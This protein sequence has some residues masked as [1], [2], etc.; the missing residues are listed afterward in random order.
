MGQH[1]LSLPCE[2]EE[3]A[4]SLPFRAAN[5]RGTK[6]EFLEN[7]PNDPG[8]SPCIKIIRVA[9]RLGGQFCLRSGVAVECTNP[10][11]WL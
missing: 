8:I 9:L 7:W 2:R 11:V 3:T 5:D 6:Q 4:V 1:R 10:F